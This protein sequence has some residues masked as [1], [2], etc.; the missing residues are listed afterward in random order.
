[1]WCLRSANFRD[2]ILI[3]ETGPGMFMFY[4]IRASK[5]L[6]SSNNLLGT[7]MLKANEGFVV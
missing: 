3:V 7:V 4:D 1:M 5:R 2:N 6:E